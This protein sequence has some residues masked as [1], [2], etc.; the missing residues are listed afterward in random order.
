MADQQPGIGLEGSLYGAVNTLNTL[1]SQIEGRDPKTF[2][3]FSAYPFM[4]PKYAKH[5]PGRHHEFEDTMARMFIQVPSALYEKFIES[6]TDPVTQ[7]IASVISGDDAG[8][9]GRGYLDFLLQNAVHDFNE[10]YQIVETL[11]DNYVAFFFGHRAPIFSYQGTLINSY[12]DDWAMRMFR[13]FRDL[14]RGTQ[15]ARRGFLLRI[16]Y[17]SMIVSGAM[18]NF[19]WSLNADMQIAC[20]FS[21][22]LLV[23]NI[24]I[25]LGGLSN[26]TDLIHESKH[27]SPEG[28]H[29][30]NPVRMNTPPTKTAIGVPSPN[31]PA[32]LPYGAST[33]GMEETQTVNRGE[34][35]EE[36]DV[37]GTPPNFSPDQ[38]TPSSDPGY[39]L[40]VFTPGAQWP[41]A[42]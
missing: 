37:T 28:F 14:G 41:P 10:K 23:K 12:Q 7:Q 25:I 13:I 26:P 8:K 19:N 20:P 34:P 18:L 6:L 22:N 39:V 40:P 33:P 29:L 24:Q 15:L 30:E 31:N 1:Y 27:F 17:D 35:D 38:L 5:R 4:S 32:E 2:G 21:F 9:G 11:S 3:V 16:R 36:A 42:A